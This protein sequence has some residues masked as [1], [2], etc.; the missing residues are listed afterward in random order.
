MVM[1]F[2]IPLFSAI[3]LTS[4][5]MAAPPVEVTRFHLD[6]AIPPGKIQMTGDSTLE[7][8]LYKD[9]LVKAL[10]ARGFEDIGMT[11]IMPT[12]RVAW[13][14]TRTVR[15]ERKRS[16]FSVGIGGSTGGRVGVGV[17]TRI[18]LGSKK[19]QIV[20]TQ[21]SVTITRTS[22]N[23][24][25]WEGRASTEVKSKSPEAQPKVLAEKLSSV[26]FYDFPGRS[27]ETITVIEND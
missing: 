2:I 11:R 4:P 23:Q 25:V 18:G 22:D 7:G 3:L 9:N 15:E 14:T 5:V 12:Y 1:R 26:L 21:L 13:T 6:Q 10:A 16:P 8:A 19:R 27:G 20:I 24:R 17:G